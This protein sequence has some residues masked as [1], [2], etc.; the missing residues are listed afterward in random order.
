MTEDHSGQSPARI[1]SCRFRLALDLSAPELERLCAE[2]LSAAELVAFAD[3]RPASLAGLVAAK[4]ALVAF[5][6][7]LAD[8]DPR[9][10]RLAHDADGRPLL[11]LLPQALADRGCRVEWYDLSISHS[12]LAA[13]ALVAGP[14][15]VS[16]S[17]PAMGQGEAASR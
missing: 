13:H 11:V 4:Q 16:D 6:S 5:F 14:D 7:A 1:A 10:F 2:C 3:R 15:P 17:W 12:R 9:D 8:C